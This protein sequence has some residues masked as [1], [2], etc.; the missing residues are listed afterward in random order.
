MLT[1]CEQVTA[2]YSLLEQ[3]NLL[4]AD[5]QNQNTNRE[6]THRLYTL[7]L[8]QCINE[9]S[10]YKRKITSLD[11]IWEK[12]S[13]QETEISEERCKLTLIL[14]N[15]NETNKLETAIKEFEFAMNQ[16]DTN[17]V[18]EIDTNDK[19]LTDVIGFWLNQCSFILQILHGDIC[20]LYD[21]MMLLCVKSRIS[22]QQ[23]LRL[24]NVDCD[25]YNTIMNTFDD[26]DD[27]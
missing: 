11:E 1:F 6:M 27:W 9:I 16:I 4:N 23:L 20:D 15:T 18:Y 19:N 10:Y 5:H 26:D 12:F 13:W 14:Q 2:V 8:M 25:L 21:T 24:K 17:S 3:H 7:P 22:V